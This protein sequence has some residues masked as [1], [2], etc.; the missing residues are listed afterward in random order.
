[1]TTHID[2]EVSRAVWNSL[3]S[4]MGGPIDIDME[5]KGCEPPIGDHDIDLCV[6]MVGWVNVPDSDRGDFGRRRVVDISIFLGEGGGCFFRGFNA[7]M[8]SMQLF[9]IAFHSKWGLHITCNKHEGMQRFLI[10]PYEVLPALGYLQIQIKWSALWT[11]VVITES[12]SL[13][14]ARA[15]LSSGLHQSEISMTCILTTTQWFY[16]WFL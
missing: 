1:M 4:G 5:W 11:V 10:C 8:V 3:I 16:L 15:W 6:T 2:I 14:H 9:W 12:S 7:D 13:H